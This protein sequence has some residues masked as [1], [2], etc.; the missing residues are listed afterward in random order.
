[1]IVSAEQLE[2]IASTP[3]RITDARARARFSITLHLAGEICIVRFEDPEAGRLFAQRYAD[4]T[5]IGNPVREAF[6]L[7]E[8]DLGYLF[9]LGGDTV[10]RWPHGDLSPEAV[11]FL[12][13]AVALTAFILRRDDGLI[14]L[15]AAVAGVDAGVAAIIGDS[16]AGKTTTA[17]ACARIRMHLYSDERALID[18]Q[19]IVHPFQRAL[20][21]RN[22][23]LRLLAQDALRGDDAIG[24]LL[25]ARPDGAWD[26]VP[27]SDLFGRTER[28][29]RP[30]RAVFLIAGAAPE[31]LLEPATATQAAK[32]AARW[33]YGAGRGLEKVTR[34]LELFNGVPCFSLVLGTPDASARAIRDALETACLK[35]SV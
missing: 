13:D 7:R 15:H 20:N 3:V 18:R 31:P 19:R 6:A 16:H 5:T 4:L 30:L 34:L 14:S 11:A 24:A 12:A 32:A 2:A 17:L 26:N 23:G 25:R 28:R 22:A 33:A 29:R 35:Q 27:F 9:W 10:F 1:V 21:I 8:P